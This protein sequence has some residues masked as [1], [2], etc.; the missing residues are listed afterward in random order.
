MC[1]HCYSEDDTRAQHIDPALKDAGW[2][3]VEGS[4]V[5]RNHPITMGRLEGFGRRAQPLKSRLRSHLSQHQKSALSRRKEWHQ[6]LTEGVAQA[7]KLRRKNGDS[8][9]RIPAMAR[10]CTASTWKP[11]RKARSLGFQR[12]MN[13]G[14]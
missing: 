5:S 8:L 12:R 13:C 14:R 6:E 11:A 4:R 1:E 7:K 2:G 3:V 10:A 9:Q